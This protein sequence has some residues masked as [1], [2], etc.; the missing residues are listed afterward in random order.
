MCV[1]VFT[2]ACVHAAR[3]RDRNESEWGACSR[4]GAGASNSDVYAVCTGELFDVS[5]RERDQVFRDFVGNSAAQAVRI[6]VYANVSATTGEWSMWAGG[7]GESRSA[8]TY[9]RFAGSAVLGGWTGSE[10]MCGMA[11]RSQDWAWTF[12]GLHFA[13]SFFVV[14]VYVCFH[15]RACVCACVCVYVCVC[16]RACMR[17]CLCSE[18]ACGGF[19]QV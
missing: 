5:E 16:A 9:E 8:M 4:A 19:L 3:S 1:C 17:V 12:L 6:P 10:Q 13:F 14:C 18:H 11:T 15:V 7:D 2:C